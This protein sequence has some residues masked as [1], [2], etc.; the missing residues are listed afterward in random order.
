MLNI[1]ITV[2]PDA[3]A[4][5]LKIIVKENGDTLVPETA[6][7]RAFL[8]VDG[9]SDPQYGLRLERAPKDGDEVFES[10]GVKIFADNKIAAFLGGFEIS[11]ETN[12]LLGI[13]KFKI[14]NPNAKSTCDYGQSFEVKDDK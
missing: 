6:G 5:L 4:K 10:N 1:M 14:S 12:L 7:L 11:L 13:N 3:A 8:V 9:C 2:T